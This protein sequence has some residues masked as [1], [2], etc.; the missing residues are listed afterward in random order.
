[1]WNTG[2]NSH[3]PVD[4]EIADDYTTPERLLILRIEVQKDGAWMPLT[5]NK[6]VAACKILVDD[7]FP[8]VPERTGIA[9]K[10]GNFTKYVQGNWKEND[11]FWWIQK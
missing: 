11:D 9:N 1:M 2:H 10:F 4:F 5:A 8:I 6:G 7:R 3:E